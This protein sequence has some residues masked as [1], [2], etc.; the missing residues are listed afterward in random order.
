LL[1]ER[2]ELGALAAIQT[3]HMRLSIPSRTRGSCPN[4]TH[5]SVLSLKHTAL[6][7]HRPGQVGCL[8]RT[9]V[10]VTTSRSLR[11]ARPSPRCRGTAVFC[12]AVGGVTSFPGTFNEGDADVKA[13]KPAAL[14]RPVSLPPPPNGGSMLEVLP[15][16][17]QLAVSDHQLWWR[18]GTAVILMFASKAAGEDTS[19]YITTPT[20]CARTPTTCARALLVH[21]K[22]CMLDTTRR[23][24]WS[25]QSYACWIQQGGLRKGV[26]IR[27]RSAKEGRC[28]VASSLGCRYIS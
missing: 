16:L 7:R 1:P 19:Q 24:F 13:R 9:D 2:P 3:L 25:M 8:R 14:P 28:V 12:S 23:I 21:A 20:T 15:Y 26:I 5:V 22:L 4:A 27:A 18:L 11:A 6:C 10:H 17:V